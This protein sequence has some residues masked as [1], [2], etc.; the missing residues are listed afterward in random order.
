MEKG[1]EERLS[2]RLHGLDTGMYD[3]GRVIVPEH[4]MEILKALD[5]S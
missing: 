3:F 5:D 1:S 4:I 2:R